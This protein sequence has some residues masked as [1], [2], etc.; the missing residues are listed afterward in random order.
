M[1]NKQ[2]GNFLAALLRGD[3]NEPEADKP[4]QKSSQN[5][6]KYRCAFCWVYTTEWVVDSMG[7][8]VCENEEECIQRKRDRMDATRQWREAREQEKTRT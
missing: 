2:D 7:K 8:Y 5:H 4:A 6:E 1:E 3:E